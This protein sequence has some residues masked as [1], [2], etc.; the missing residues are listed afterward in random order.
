M[1]DR[2]ARLTRRQELD[3]VA[4]LRRDVDNA[5]TV[6]GSAGLLWALVEL[7]DATRPLGELVL[8]LAAG[9]TL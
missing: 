3:A 6:L 9:G 1:R 5:L 8:R 2:I 4:G 7:V